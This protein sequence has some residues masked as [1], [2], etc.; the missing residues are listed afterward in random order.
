MRSVLSRLGIGWQVALLAIVG[1][2]GVLVMIGINWRG[3]NQLAR[4]DAVTDNVRQERAIET[5]IQI[6]MLQ[7]RRHEKDFLLR[8][9]EKYAA[10]QRDATAAALHDAELLT[11]RVADQSDLADLVRLM[12]ADVTRYAAAF[13]AVVQNA[14]A[15][16]LNENQGLLGAL[17]SAVREVEE[18]LK[19]LRCRMRRLPC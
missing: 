8:R 13:A 12:S 19:S 2:I 5:R 3:A 4:N 9:D 7:A 10:M 6:E 16:G 15:V 14:K 11:A 18:G 1:V 17:R